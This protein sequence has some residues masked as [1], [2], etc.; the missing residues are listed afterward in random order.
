[1]LLIVFVAVARLPESLISQIERARPLTEGQAGWVFRLMLLA[2]LVQ[3]AYGG[4]AVLRPERVGSALARDPKLARMDRASIVAMVARNA[5]G[6][7]ALT[8]V[9]GL[10]CTGLTGERGGFWLFALL[11]VAQGAYYYRQTGLI[12]R[13][14]ALQPEPA[15]DKRTGEWNRE[16]PDYSPPLARGLDGGPA[17]PSSTR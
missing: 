14:L 2:A 5:A 8:V 17:R 10:A 6:M 1:V 12:A 9:Y 15:P 11:A 4:F 3:A 7:V 16:P 13:W